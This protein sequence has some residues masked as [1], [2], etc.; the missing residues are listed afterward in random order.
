MLSDDS[1]HE[2]VKNVYIKQFPTPLYLIKATTIIILTGAVLFAIY[3]VKNILLLVII[4][5]VIAI[6]LEPIIYSAMRFLHI[7]RF[8]TILLIVL[9]TLTFV[10]LFGLFVIPPLV[11]Q[12]TELS[13]AIPDALGRI[14]RR[15][16]WLGKLFSDN[17]KTI[18]DFIA[19]LP[20]RIVKSFGTIVG[21]TGQIGGFLVNT[22]T[23]AVLSIF[24]INQLPGL[25][26]RIS[27]LFEPSRR[28]LAIV[29]INKMIEKIGS[30]V[31]GNLLTS[32]ICTIATYIALAILGIPYSIPLA[33]WAGI[34]D[35]IPQIGAFIG[36]AP[37]VILAFYR[38]PFIGIVTII[39]FVVYQQVENFLITPKVMQKA[40]NLSPSSVLIATLIG[41]DLAG[42]VGILLA[43]P[44]AAVLKVFL[45]DIWY[46]NTIAKVHKLPQSDTAGTIPDK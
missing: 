4:A 2:Q 14:G 41:G 15:S 46:P 37:A 25:A 34:T 8:L 31:S 20:S 13:T 28:S 10:S 7:N 1:R 36:A 16:D 9:V 6:G 3:T 42:V 19:G 39:F 5:A 11:H 40:V 35:L 33:M 23:V 18:Q 38:S 43:L 29:T 32:L 22:I 17:Q 44:I 30:F 27:L 24:F 26:K 45:T 21:I 12:I